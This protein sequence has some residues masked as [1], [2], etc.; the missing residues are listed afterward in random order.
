MFSYDYNEV[1]KKLIVYIP[2]N[3]RYSIRFL[4]A[5]TKLMKSIDIYQCE[6]ISVVSA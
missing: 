3:I 5:I 4:Y 1:E 6:R 2:A